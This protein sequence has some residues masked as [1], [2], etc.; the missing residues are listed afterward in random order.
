MAGPLSYKLD[1][2]L[3]HEG[4]YSTTLYEYVSGLAETIS[5]DEVEILCGHGEW[6]CLLSP[7]GCI[8]MLAGRLWHCSEKPHGL[9]HTDVPIPNIIWMWMVAR[10]LLNQ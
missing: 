7:H 1:S 5:L 10:F 3:F 6:C 4:L 2:H 9:R 8:S